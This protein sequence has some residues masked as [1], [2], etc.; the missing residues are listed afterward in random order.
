MARPKLRTI[1]RLRAK[2]LAHPGK[3]TLRAYLQAR[4]KRGHYD[5]RMFRYYGLNPMVNAGCRAATVRAY[6]AGLVPT[7]T[8]RSPIGIGSYHNARNLRREGQAVDFGLIESEIGTEKGR[9]RMVEFQKAEHW[10]HRNRKLKHDLIELIGPD[11][12]AIVLRDR[13]TDLVEGTPLETQ[14][15]THVHE[16]YRG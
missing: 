8:L 10:R 11:N 1:R 9:R 3:L 14:H 2:Y 5:E 16:S 15:D 12:K 4:A 13:E 6:A 7:S